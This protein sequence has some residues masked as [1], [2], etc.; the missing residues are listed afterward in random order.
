[1]ADA[2]APAG[3]A[4]SVEH[5]QG[6][7]LPGVVVA[8]AT[9]AVSGVAVFANSYGVRAVPQAAVYTTAKNLIA[10]VLLVAWAVV[11]HRRSPAA[12]RAR[13]GAAGLRAWATVAYVGVVGGGLAFVLFFTGLAR[14][15]AE[16]AAF[17]HDTQV[18]WVAA[19]ALPLLG[20]RLSPWNVAAIAGLVA[21]Q[22]ATTGGVGHLVVGPGAA[23]VLGATVLWALEAV[24]SRRLLLA[25]VQPH[26]LAALRMG[27][28]AVALVCFLVVTGATGALVHLQGAQWRWVL[29]A[30]VLL[31]AYVATWMT[32]L[33]RARA[34]DVT[35][36]LVS[37]VVVTALLQSAAGHAALAPKAF[38]LVLVVVGVAGVLWRL[39][40]RRLAR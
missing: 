28:G 29:V 7:R 37:S 32:A 20:E 24:L 31:G 13:F 12:A 2:V 35:S 30:G 4:V 36:V 5:R 27:L 10:A 1:M 23:L 26:E 19:L 11:L 40:E 18:V 17:L 15:T 16:P 6:R 22:V 34:V 38:G 9:A 3:R 25:G 21:G 14:S 39:P 8:G 33:S